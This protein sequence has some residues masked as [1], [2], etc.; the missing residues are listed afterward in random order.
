[1][2]INQWLA[3]A[4]AVALGLGL[5]T[6]AI[7]DVSIEDIVNDAKTTDDVV[8]AGLGGQNQRYSPLAKISKDNVAQLV[9]KWTMSLGGEKMRGQES[10]ALVKDGVMY[11]TG[12]YSRMWAIDIKTGREI[13]QYDHRLPEG[14]LP[15]CD[16]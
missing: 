13:W 6:S 1:M 7:A 11:I 3:T 4:S 8:T 10:Q 2:K 9:P 16:V 12:S 15:C 14:I 5:A